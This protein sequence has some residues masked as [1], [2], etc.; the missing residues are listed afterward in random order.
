[1]SDTGLTGFERYSIKLN[2]GD[3][4]VNQNVTVTVDNGKEFEVLVRLDTEPEV[5]YY[6]NGGILQTV[7]RKLT[8]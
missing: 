4:K 3:L 1:M 7:L 2:G 8:N 6:R 5:Q